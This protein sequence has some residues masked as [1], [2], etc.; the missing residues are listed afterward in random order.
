MGQIIRLPA[1]SPAYPD[2]AAV[3][4]ASERALLAGIRCW[5]SGFRQ[6]DDPLPDLCEAM[7][8][9][10]VHDAAF[11]VDQLMA[12]FV[13]SSK[14]QIVIHCPRCPALSDDEKQLLNAASLAQAGESKM[15]ERTL[16][17]TLL[18]AQG[19]EFAL[20]PLTGLGELFAEAK[21]FFRRRRPPV[22]DQTPNAVQSG[23]DIH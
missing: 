23:S 8:A 1:A 16:R 10:G 2:N 4:D 22:V 13:R 15:A 17:T 3:L 18:S 12:I 9:A 14:R 20:G 19:A 11:S 21:L 6:R 5:V 7:G